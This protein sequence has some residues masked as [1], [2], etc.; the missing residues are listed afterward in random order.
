[1]R[2]HGKPGGRRE[3]YVDTPYSPGDVEARLAEVIGDRA[4]A[5]DFFARYIQGTEVADYE[6]LLRNAGFVVRKRDAGRAWLGDIRMDPRTGGAQVA[7][8]VP[9]NS[10]AYAAGIDQGDTIT[11]VGSERTSSAEEVSAAISR[12]RPGDRISVAY[13]DRGGVPRTATV[14]LIENPH[15]EVVPVES[16]G[17]SLTPAQRAFRD[18]WL[19]SQIH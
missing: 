7:A 16:A 6:R 3:G 14:T 5:R 13:V 9:A 18:R 2:A 15:L 17:G 19:N 11:Q 4:F 10:P 8:E 1:W 12:R